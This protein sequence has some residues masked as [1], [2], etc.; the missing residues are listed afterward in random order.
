[1][2]APL[3][4]SD[5]DY[6][7]RTLSD[8]ER[9]AI[10]DFFFRKEVKVTL[11]PSTT[12]IVVP[13]NQSANTTM[14]DFAVLV[15]FALGVLTVSGFE[16]V[17]MVAT[18]HASTCSDALQRSNRETPGAPRFAKKVVKSAASIWIRHC[19]T[20]R[21]KTKNKLHITAE[22][23]CTLRKTGPLARCLSRFVHLPGVTS[24]EPN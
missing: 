5:A 16:P 17:T 24:R 14:E 20:A 10:E 19:F 9:L 21:R 8:R 22:P 13:H 11:S 18:L 2:P 23:I 6:A 4:G 1:M 3:H 7:I 12:A 15:E